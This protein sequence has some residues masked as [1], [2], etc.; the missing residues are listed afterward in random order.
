M[1]TLLI[2]WKFILKN[3]KL[4]LIIVMALLL[5]WFWKSNKALK[6][7]NARVSENF[8][9]VTQENSRILNLNRSELKNINAKWKTSF[10]SIREVHRIALKSVKSATIIQTQYK[11][12][13]STKI[14]Y[15]PLIKLPDS[16]YKISVESEQN[17]CWSM[18]GF[19]SS[20]DPESKL[21]VTE[22]T[23]NN[24]VQ[25]LI[26]RKRFLGFLWYKKNSEKL[27]VFGNC[28]ELDVTQLNF[29]K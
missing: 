5:F 23:A 26:T 14:V 4:S 11:D 6:I 8:S 10:D 20:K 13:G 27:Q 21:T 19:I 1:A 16:S 29:S 28:G 3:W 25:A 24:K 17:E 7:D 9:Q 12:T 18:K 2:A 15:K 22:K